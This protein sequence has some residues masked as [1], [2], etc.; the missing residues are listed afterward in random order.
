MTPKP[1][2]VKFTDQTPMPWG[3]HKGT[4]MK[5]VPSSYLLWL[6][7]QPWIRDWPDVH[8]YLVANQDALLAEE[9]EDSPP[10]SG[11]FNSLDDY[12]RYGR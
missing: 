7:K 6:F 3:E 2:R 12:M 8:A 9:E 1:K 4:P 11:G 5:D 10:A